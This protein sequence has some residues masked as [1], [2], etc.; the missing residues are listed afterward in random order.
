M[1]LDTY[2]NITAVVKLPRLGAWLGMP[3]GNSSNDI[4]LDATIY[5]PTLD[6]LVRE[7]FAE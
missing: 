6:W 4:E 3:T 7:K 1:L 2:W 5:V